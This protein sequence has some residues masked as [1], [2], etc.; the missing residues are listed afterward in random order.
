M[1]QN[2]FVTGGARGIGEK[3]CRKI[4]TRGGRVF[5]TDINREVG[6]ET[7]RIFV[8]EFGKARAEFCVQ[9]VTD[10]DQWLE[11]WHL[12]ETF[13]GGKVRAVFSL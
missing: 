2:F 3:I 4:L 12:A 13:F 11:A 8:S 9:D 5:F 6:E 1:E 7:K 10:R